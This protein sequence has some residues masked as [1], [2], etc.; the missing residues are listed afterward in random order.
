MRDTVIKGS[1]LETEGTKVAAKARTACN[2]LSRAQQRQLL[3]YG[4]ARIYGKAK[5]TG[6]RHKSAA[7]LVTSDHHLLD[8]DEAALLLAFAESRLLPVSPSH[9]RRLLRALR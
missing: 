1:R 7:V 2:K 3:E 8:L 4:K 5:G 9:P 6:T